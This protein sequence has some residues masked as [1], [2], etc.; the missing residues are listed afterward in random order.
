MPL[1]EI[2]DKKVKIAAADLDG[3]L[4]GK[5]I[6]SKKFESGLKNGLGFCSVIFGW[7]SADACYDYVPFT[8]WHNGYPDAN[9][10]LDEST[11]RVIPWDNNTPFFLGDFVTAQ[12]TP[13]SICPRQV[14]KRTLARLKSAGFL[15][16][17]GCEYEWFNFAETPKSLHEKKFTDI[18][19]LTPGMFG[20]SLIRS[21]QNHPYFSSLM[22]NLEAFSIPLEGI[23]TETGPGVYEA[24]I[25]AGP[26]LEAADR[27]LLFKTAV[28]EIAHKHDVVASFM[29]RWNTDLPGCGGHIHQSLTDLDGHPLFYDSR[30][31][32]GMSDLFKH[33]IAGQIKCL[34]HIL[35][36]VAPTV[37][38][39]KRLVKGYWAPTRAN[40]GLDNRT[41]ALR[42]IRGGEK[43]TRVEFR[44][45]GSDIN[46]FLAL[47]ASLESGL[48]GISQKLALEQKPVIGNGYQD[49]SAEEFSE[50]LLSASEVFKNSE[51]TRTLFDSEFIDHFYKT[52]VW[53]W[54]Q[55]QKAV[56]D[57]ELKRYFEII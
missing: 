11:Y 25:C 21:S 49:E 10:V 27:A 47:A 16:T 46:P 36:M 24:A 22:E 51:I 32:D 19:P 41:C 33:F 29:S 9:L 42:V 48:Y 13:L 18:T 54:Q 23:H 28:K 35:P 45:S 26:A 1:S 57:W 37:N 17:V 31:P 7:D 50:N 12:N 30:S 55:Y 34:P 3:V 40:W 14:L 39:Y 15:A 5:Y 38:S 20:Y 8:G 52:R 6:H 2:K 56:S 44:A 43:S 4:R 53:E